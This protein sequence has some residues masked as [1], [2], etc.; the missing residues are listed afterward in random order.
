MLPFIVPRLTSVTDRSVQEPPAL[1]CLATQMRTQQ[2]VQGPPPAEA[3]LATLQRQTR[4]VGCSVTPQPTPSRHRQLIYSEARPQLPIRRVE[5]YLAIPRMLPLLGLVV[6]SGRLQTR[7]LRPPA[8]SLVRLLPPP[9]QQ[10]GGYSGAQQLVAACSAPNLA[11]PHNNPLFS[12]AS[13]KHPETHSSGQP[14]SS[15]S[16]QGYLG[17]RSLEAGCSAAAR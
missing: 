15:N 1:I 5:A 17:S 14:N 11:P 16:N 3:C 13:P 9:P 4:E 2:Q 10:E 8:A 6:C 7:P 12:E